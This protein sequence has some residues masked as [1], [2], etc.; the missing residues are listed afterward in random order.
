MLTKEFAMRWTLLDRGEL[1]I[2]ATR[3]NITDDMGGLLQIDIDRYIL[4]C[5]QAEG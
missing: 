1:H 2:I 5:Q 4:N 3:E